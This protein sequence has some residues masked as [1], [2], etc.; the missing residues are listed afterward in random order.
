MLYR[1]T[2][3][4]EIRTFAMSERP[5]GPLCSRVKNTYVT[6][7]GF[8]WLSLKS[9]RRSAYNPSNI[10]YHVLEYLFILK[11][12]V[13]TSLKNPDPFHIPPSGLGP[14]TP[15][16]L[17]RLLYYTRKFIKGLA[18]QQGGQSGL[19]R[20]FSTSKRYTDH[21]YL[22]WACASENCQNFACYFMRPEKSAIINRT[23]WRK[24]YWTSKSPPMRNAGKRPISFLYK[25]LRQ[26]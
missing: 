3:L 13:S 26:D 17:A 4:L 2:G 9:Q 23:I 7:I 1:T 14:Q 5:I 16:L 22:G 24:E 19:F 10:L 20:G 15:S 12:S 18:R 21:G 6:F 25:N 8:Q 11:V